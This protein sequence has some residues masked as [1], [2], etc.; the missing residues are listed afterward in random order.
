MRCED[1][2]LALQQQLDDEATAVDANRL[3]EHAGMCRRCRE[4]RDGL[5]LMTDC[6]AASRP[7]RVPA[8][9]ADRICAAAVPARTRR[10]PRRIPW[11]A[12]AALIGA[13]SLLVRWWTLDLATDDDGMEPRLLMAPTVEQVESR[14][15]RLFPELDGPLAADLRQPVAIRDAVEPVSRL[16]QAVGKSLGGPIRPIAVSTSE[17]MGNLIR[18]LP[19]P[20]SPLPLPMMDMLGPVRPEMSEMGPSS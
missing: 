18:D 5:A 15:Q 11:L 14:D 10:P 17:A 4:L 13:A 6:F 3:L 20:D 2:E 16:F 1:F 7:V 8:A 9:L 19:D 12:A